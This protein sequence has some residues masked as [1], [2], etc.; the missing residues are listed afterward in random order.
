VTYENKPSLFELSAAPSATEGEQDSSPAPLDDLPLFGH[1]EE[2]EP[3]PESPIEEPLDTGPIG[4]EQLEVAFDAPASEATP[5][6]PVPS[7]GPARLTDR[8]G[9]ALLDLAVMAGAVIALAGGAAILGATP[10]PSD[11]PLIAFP[12]LLFSFLYHVVPMAFWGRTPGM[13]SMS[14]VARTLDDRPLS[15]GQAVR[16]WLATL[17]TAALLGIPGLLA[18]SGR[19]ATDRLSQSVTRWK[20][21]TTASTA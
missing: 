11:W 1:L 5:A 2:P 8:L 16:R 4:G 12:W 18:L 6:T 10:Q 9:A 13:A 17:A 3:E 21:P 15:L 19:S 7:E 14:L 20:A